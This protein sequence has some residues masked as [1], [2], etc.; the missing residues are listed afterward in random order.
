M[1]FGIT[2]LVVASYV[3]RQITLFAIGGLVGYFNDEN[4]PWKL[5][6]IG[7]A[8]PALLTA[9]INARQVPLPQT[10]ST[11]AAPSNK[12]SPSAKVSFFESLMIPSAC[13]D[14]IEPDGTRVFSLPSES[15]SQQFARGYFGSTPGNIWYVIVGS[16]RDKE[17]AFAQADAIRASGFSANVY[18]PY[19]AAHRFFSVVIGAQMPRDA[20]ELLKQRAIAAGLSPDTYLWTFPLTSY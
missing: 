8:A 19:G 9:L 4:N 7:I 12:A 3:L 15:Y 5:F 13:A 10:L 16:F 11:I 6:Q 20:A 2:F 17:R 18:R 1:T 14:E